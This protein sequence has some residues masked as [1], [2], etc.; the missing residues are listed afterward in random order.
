MASCRDA[1]IA[2]RSG[3]VAGLSAGRALADIMLARPSRAPPTRR[4]A[5]PSLLGESLIVGSLSFGP[6]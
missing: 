2:G 5:P 3:P 6:I 4:P 1:T